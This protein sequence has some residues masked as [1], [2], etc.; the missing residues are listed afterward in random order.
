MF[1]ALVVAAGVAGTALAQPCDPGSRQF[2][3]EFGNSW[4]HNTQN[5]SAGSAL[6]VVG[7]I[8]KTTPSNPGR[9]LNYN[10]ASTSEYTFHITGVDLDQFV[11]NGTAVP[12]SFRYGSG[13]TITVYYDTSKDAP[14]P[15]PINPPNA[16]V[17][18]LFIDGVPILVGTIDNLLITFRDG[19]GTNPDS[20]GE[21]R[22]NVTFTGGDSLSALISPIWVWNATSADGSF[23]PAGYNFLWGGELKN[24]CIPTG[25]CCFP[26]GS[27]AVLTAAN[28]AAQGGTYAGDGVTC[29]AAQ[30][31]Q[32]MEACCFNDGSCVVVLLGQCPQGSIPQGNGSTCATANCPDY[33]GACCYSDGSCVDGMLEADCVASGGIFQGGGSDCASA[34]CVNFHG[35]CCLPNGQCIDNTLE[36]GCV[37]AGGTFQGNGTSCA[38]VSCP[39][40]TEA[41]CFAATGACADLLPGECVA[42]GGTPQGPGSTCAGVVCPQP[43][44]RGACCRPDGSCDD[45]VLEGECTATG[46]LWYPNMS[47]ADVQCV[48]GVEPKTWGE[49]KGIYR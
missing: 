22:G 32:P 25:A 49:L 34:N 27:C 42:Q 2:I 29:A 40:P 30:C 8:N 16:T 33:T 28:C 6:E 18:A 12:D 24:D 41:C 44:P 21:I 3:L 15:P 31:P 20:I 4:G 37:A 13:G 43:P 14:R 48:N 19:A 39:Q 1:A 7:R 46:G 47:C 23:N 26:D 45:G 10:T 38:N 5:P 11:N 9:P 36:A 17:P 35:A